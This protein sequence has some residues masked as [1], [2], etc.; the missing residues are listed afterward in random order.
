MYLAV[1]IDD[2]KERPHDRIVLVTPLLKRL[3]AAVALLNSQKRE[4]ATSMILSGD[5]RALNQFAY[6][7]DQA[8][9][10]WVT[11][12]RDR[13][14]D[15]LGVIAE[16]AGCSV[17]PFDGTEGHAAATWEEEHRDRPK[18]K[19]HPKPGL[20]PRLITKEGKALWDEVVEQYKATIARFK[21]DKEKMWAAAI[22]IFKRVAGERGIRPFSKD[23]SQIDQGKIVTKT[24]RIINRG[25][26]KALA[27]IEKAAEMLQKEK[28]AKRLTNEKFYEAA[29]EAGKWYVTT[30]RV[31]ETPDAK[32]ALQLL[33]EK[34]WGMGTG[35]YLHRTVDTYTDVLAEPMG[36]NKLYFYVATHLTRDLMSVLFPTLRN[37]DAKTIMRT[38]S[39]A[40]RQWVKTGTMRAIAAVDLGEFVDDGLRQDLADRHLLRSWLMLAGR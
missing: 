4:D 27:S 39:K 7:V 11:S 6:L 2:G 36:Q 14:V 30:F 34:A 18:P 13:M 35:G 29:N 5:E 21:S 33:A 28:L 40:G 19:R 9:D 25:N 20:Y 1:W 10:G 15:A 26:H 22:L 17:V 8:D 12:N 37:A 23:V 16:K 38:L 32:R 31:L 3:N 24:H